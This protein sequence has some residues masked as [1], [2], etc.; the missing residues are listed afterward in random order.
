MLKSPFTLPLLTVNAGLV[1]VFGL[2]G[3]LDQMIRWF[4]DSILGF[5]FVFFVL[6]LFLYWLVA[7]IKNAYLEWKYLEDD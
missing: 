5:T 4:N 6:Y 2:L 1:A 7:E 3:K